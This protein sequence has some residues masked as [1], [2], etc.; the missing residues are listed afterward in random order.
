MDSDWFSEWFNSPYYHIL[1]KNRDQNE[2]NRFIDN[3]IKEFEPKPDAKVLDLACGKGRHSVYLNRK[4]LNVTGV[5]LA[6]ESIR[7]A[8]QFENER[9]KFITGDMR[10][11]LPN[12]FDFIFNLFT[13][14]GYFDDPEDDLKTLTAVKEMLLPEGVFVLDFF[15][16]HKVVKHLVA[17]EEKVES[18]IPFQLERKVVDGNIIKEIRFRD[19]GRD[20]EFA[21]K[22]SAIYK[23]DFEAY[24]KKVGFEVL[25]VWGDYG[26]TPYDQESSPRMIFCLKSI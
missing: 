13:S 21:E 25:N 10:V 2:A 16:T 20:Y 4:G 3:L 19:N 8:K 15:N 11:S 6:E 26:L 24:F 22:V 12:Q 9:L 23:N 7:H 1:Y 5:D 17:H 18:G 14:F